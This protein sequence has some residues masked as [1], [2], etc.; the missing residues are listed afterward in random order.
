MH[1]TSAM[2]QLANFIYLCHLLQTLYCKIF[3][4]YLSTIS[5]IVYNYDKYIHFFMHFIHRTHISE[6]ESFLFF[7]IFIV[8][9][10]ESWKIMISLANEKYMHR[11]FEITSCF[12][13]NYVQI[14]S[15]S[16]KNHPHTSIF[17][18]RIRDEMTLRRDYI[19]LYLHIM[20]KK[21]RSQ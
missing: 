20:K 14:L 19:F 15:I 4:F 16:I 9:I 6:H 17:F 12:P 2:I 11:K 1:R 10:D 21:K 18:F 3:N 7:L 5:I 8:K 13:P